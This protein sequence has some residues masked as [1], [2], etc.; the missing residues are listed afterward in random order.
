LLLN[1]IH[2]L[3]FFYFRPGVHVRPSNSYVTADAAL[4]QKCLEIPDLKDQ[5]H[6]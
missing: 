1:N 2:V 6:S 5:N 4:G 3:T